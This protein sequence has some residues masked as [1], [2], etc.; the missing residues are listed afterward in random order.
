[1]VDHYF[2]EKPSAKGKAVSFSCRIRGMD[3]SFLS[4][5]S[6]FSV[7]KLDLGTK[8]LAESMNVEDSK[9]I[10]DIGCGIGILGIVCS[11][12]SPRAIIAMSDINES[13]LLSSKKNAEINKCVNVDIIKSDLYS[14]INSKFDAII[15]N[16]PQ[17]AGKKVCF[18]L[19]EG[20]K[21]H[22]N[23]NGTLQIVARHQKGGK[24]LEKKMKEVFGNVSV[25]ARQSGY[26]VYL[27]VNK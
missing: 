27:S 7:G 17:K 4:S 21:Q 23:P 2:S 10:L 5:P 14:S 24:E 11:K 26:R 18:A 8:V 12:I 3:F 19:I 6:T 13:S 1:M 25:L 16:P 20:A 9:T 15:S 22:L